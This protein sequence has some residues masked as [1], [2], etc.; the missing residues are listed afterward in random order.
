MMEPAGVSEMTISVLD[1]KPALVVIDLQKGIVAMPTAHPMQGVIDNCVALAE[2]FRKHK[3][4]V[5][6]VNVDGVPPGR[7]ERSLSLAQMPAG[8]TDL[9]P[10]LNRQP[11]DHVVTKRT[12]GAFTNTDLEKHLR[13]ASVTQVI[14][15]GVA[16]SSGVEST[17][18][19][20]HEL[21]FH[22]VLVI[23]AMTD[24]D[25]DAHH[26]SVVRIFPKMSETGTTEQLLGLIAKRSA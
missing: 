16:T 24:T 2:A 23:D 15:V 20:A 11:S 3:L 25:A 14:V 9:I 21:G 10:E 8:W 4:P 6:L 7:A 22:V 12:R 1:A 5:V 26:N 13:Q 17:A 18:R 19:Q